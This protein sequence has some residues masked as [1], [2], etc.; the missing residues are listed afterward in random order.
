M[1]YTAHGTGRIICEGVDAEV[2]YSIT[3][4]QA[5]VNATHME[6][7]ASISGMKHCSGTISFADYRQQDAAFNCRGQILVLSDGR[8]IRGLYQGPGSGHVFT[9]TL[10]D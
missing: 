2:E 1:G 7:T 5:E 10:L 4:D 8:R 9:G 3:F 6:G